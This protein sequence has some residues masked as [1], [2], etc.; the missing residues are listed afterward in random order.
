ML[1]EHHL[2]PNWR[3]KRARTALDASLSRKYVF[4]LLQADFSESLIYKQALLA[5]LVD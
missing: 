4:T 3:V 1:L 5:A 2:G